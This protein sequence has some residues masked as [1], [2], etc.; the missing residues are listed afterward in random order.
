M[1]GAVTLRVPHSPVTDEE[2]QR[3]FELVQREARFSD[4][5]LPLDALASRIGRSVTAVSFMIRKLDDLGRIALRPSGNQRVVTILDTAPVWTQAKSSP[6]AAAPPP[7]TLYPVC[8]PCGRRPSP[9]EVKA[10]LRGC[11]ASRI[12]RG[13][14][15]EV[16]PAPAVRRRPVTPP[17]PPPVEQAKP[18][19]HLPPTHPFHPD[20]QSAPLSRKTELPAPQRQEGETGKAAVIRITAAR[21]EWTSSQVAAAAGVTSNYVLKTWGEIGRKVGMGRRAVSA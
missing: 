20:N 19:S 18:G 17:A 14:E 16:T 6:K 11:R 4:E 13:V 1:V 5:L 2:L 7:V 3:L 8:G 15:G 21:P 9:T 12:A 10:C